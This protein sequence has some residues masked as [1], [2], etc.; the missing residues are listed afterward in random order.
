MLAYPEVQSRARAV[1]DEEIG[2]ARPPAFAD[3]PSPLY[4]PR[5]GQRDTA[6]V[7]HDSLWRASR[8]D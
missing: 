2:S 4:Y 1:L 7:G 8:L 3:L 5:D 6:L